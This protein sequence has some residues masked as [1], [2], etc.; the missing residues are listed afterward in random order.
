M[1]H[2]A[3]VTLHDFTDLHVKIGFYGGLH[4][5]KGGGMWCNNRFISIQ[6]EFRLIAQLYM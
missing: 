6:T 3:K 4:R 5:W 2:F 1:S